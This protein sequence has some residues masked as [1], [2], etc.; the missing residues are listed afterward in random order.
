MLRAVL[1]LQTLLLSLFSFSL[2]ADDVGWSG[3]IAEAHWSHFSEASGFI[4]KIE[5]EYRHRR[6]LIKITPKFYLPSMQYLGSFLFFFPLVLAAPAVN[7]L[8]QPCRQCKQI[9]GELTQM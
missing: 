8:R 9:A 7:M 3:S 6:S 1:L 2:D 5:A 4:G